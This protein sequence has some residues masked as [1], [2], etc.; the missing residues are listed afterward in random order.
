MQMIWAAM[1]A[2]MSLS[3][4]FS[5]PA[6]VR[7]TPA[8]RPDRLGPAS[9]NQRVRLMSSPLMM[10]LAS[11]ICAGWMLWEPGTRGK[12]SPGVAFGGEKADGGRRGRDFG[13]LRRVAMEDQIRI[14]I[15]SSNAASDQIRI[16]ST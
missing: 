4:S 2:C 5:E 11:M 7:T 10:T 8:M 16:T 1:D 3:L 9:L 14:T 6:R 12:E 13:S 15:N